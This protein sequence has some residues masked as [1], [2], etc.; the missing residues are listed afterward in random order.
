MKTHYVCQNS[1]TGAIHVLELKW[2]QEYTTVIFSPCGY[3]FTSFEK[4]TNPN[5]NKKNVKICIKCHKSLLKSHDKNL[6]AHI[7]YLKLTGKYT[8]TGVN[9]NDRIKI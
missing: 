4:R 9:P 1:M 7:S 6:I 2:S 8:Y 3:G 5:L